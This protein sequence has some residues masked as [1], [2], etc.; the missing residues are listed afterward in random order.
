M[1]VCRSIYQ[2]HSV[3]LLFTFDNLLLLIRVFATYQT[4][5]LASKHEHVI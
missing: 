1:Y 3:L 4:N 5:N 2:L